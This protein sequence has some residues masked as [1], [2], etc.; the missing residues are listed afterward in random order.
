MLIRV[1]RPEDVRQQLD[2][3][4]RVSDK[5]PAVAAIDEYELIRQLPP[6]LTMVGA[7]GLSSMARSAAEQAVRP[8]HPYATVI[9]SH[10]ALAHNGL[11]G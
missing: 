10:Y 5:D 9:P 7:P 6:S 4:R 1:G 11:I 3:D 8:W 2:H